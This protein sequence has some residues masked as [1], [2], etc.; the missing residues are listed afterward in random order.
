MLSFNLNK[1]KKKYIKSLCWLLNILLNFLD[2]VS[3]RFIKVFFVIISDSD[4]VI[5]YFCIMIEMLS[6]KINKQKEGNLNCNLFWNG[7]YG[8]IFA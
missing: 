5:P 8:M 7:F 1:L 3:S 4:I 6:I 2:K